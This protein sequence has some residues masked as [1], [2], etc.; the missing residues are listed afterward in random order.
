VEAGACHD[1]LCVGGASAAT[2]TG[3]T[4]ERWSTA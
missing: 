4:L 3:A 2:A 1:H